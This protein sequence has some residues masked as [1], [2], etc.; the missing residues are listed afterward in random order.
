MAGVTLAKDKTSYPRPKAS[1]T[2]HHSGLWQL[3]GG[4]GPLPLEYSK[5]GAAH[6]SGFPALCPFGPGANRRGVL[7]AEGSGK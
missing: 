4:R 5:P 1:H 6:P 2:P 7:V 3:A